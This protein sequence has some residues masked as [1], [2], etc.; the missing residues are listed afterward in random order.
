MIYFGCVDSYAKI[1][2]L[3][4]PL[5]NSTTHTT[6]LKDII[7]GVKEVV[8]GQPE[9]VDH[10]IQNKGIKRIVT[11]HVL[12]KDV[13]MMAHSKLRASLNTFKLKFE[14]SGK[15]TKIEKIFLMECTF[16]W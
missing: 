6:I 16:N 2:I 7:K 13:I 11:A 12:L 8:L 4:P 5:E 3:Y 14:L 10:V 9:G 1:L 15:H